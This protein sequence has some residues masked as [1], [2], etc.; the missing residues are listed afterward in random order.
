MP[1]EIRKHAHLSDERNDAQ[2]ELREREQEIEGLDAPRD[3]DRMDD[4]DRKRAFTHCLKRI[5][6]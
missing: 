6:E 5:R 2:E 1:E 4:I 3:D